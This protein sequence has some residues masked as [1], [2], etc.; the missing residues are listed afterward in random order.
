MVIDKHFED[1]LMIFMDRTNGRKTS[2]CLYADVYDGG[3]GHC[4]TK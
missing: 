3:V 1:K 4:K 2:C